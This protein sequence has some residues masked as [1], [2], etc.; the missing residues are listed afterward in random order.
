MMRSIPRRFFLPQ[1]TKKLFLALVSAPLFCSFST[2]TMTITNQQISWTKIVPTPDPKH[3]SPCTRSSHGVSMVKDGTR[4]I[5]LGGEHVAR[6]PIEGGSAYWAA[7][8]DGASWKWRLISATGAPPDRI[9]HAQAVHKDCVYVFGGRAGITMEEKAMNDLWKLDCSGAAGEET[10]SQVP[11]K[12]GSSPPE[13]RSFH[14][15]ICIGDSLYVFGGCTASHGRANDLHRFDLNTNTWHSLGASQLR[16]RG[17]PNLLPF[18]GGKKVGVVAGFAGE[19]TA[20]GHLF[21]VAAAKWD[22]KM[23]EEE[24][25]GMRPRSVCVS[26]SLPSLGYSVIFGGEVDPSDRGHEGAGAFENDV[27]VLDESSGAF[28]TSL[29]KTDEIAWPQ[30]RGWSDSATVDA[31]NGIGSF[32]VFGGLSGDD[33]NPERLDDF[34]L[35]KIQK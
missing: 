2:A 32:Y 1:P 7:D 21:D 15:M 23:I 5:V 22:E 28:I 9:A 34:W 12:E 25:K 16:G 19:E 20:D 3:G 10:W 4:L 11:V 27:V 17:G 35:L 13:A 24:L 31:G 30:T 18:C 29:K 8:S 6:T 26:G 33:K 14:R